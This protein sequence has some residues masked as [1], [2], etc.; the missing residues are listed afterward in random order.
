MH[1]LRQCT[2]SGD[3]AHGHRTWE[4]RATRDATLIRQ[5]WSARAD[6]GV[7]IATGPSRLYV[8]DL[9]PAHGEPAPLRWRGALHGRDVLTRLATEHGQPYPGDTYTVRTPSG[10]LHLYFRVPAGSTLRN[11]IALAGWRVDSRGVGGSIVAAGNVRADG[12]YLVIRN[13]PI[14]PLPTWL[15]TVFQPPPPPAIPPPS[16]RPAPTVSRAR[17]DAYVRKVADGVVNAASKTAHRTLLRAAISL[18]RLI[19]DTVLCEPDVVTALRAAA[20]QRRIP[21][22]EADSTIRDGIVFGRRRTRTLPS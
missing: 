8:V 7:G 12:I 18:G 17:A 19:D 10:G 4:Q 2:R 22:Q 1:S 21:P 6:L 20:H 5:W 11:T 13:L 14:A 9:D 15:A 16:L 3:C